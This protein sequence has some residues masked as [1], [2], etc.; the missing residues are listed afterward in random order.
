MELKSALSALESH[1]T[2][3]GWKSKNKDAYFSH[4]FRMLQDEHADWQLGFYQKKKEKITTFVVTL[5]AVRMRDAEEVF[6][7]EECDIN[8][9]EI[10]EKTLDLDEVVKRANTFQQKNYPR[11]K[12][13]KIIALLQCLPGFGSV[14]NLTFVTQQLNTLNMKIHSQSGDI[15]DHKLSSVF[16]FRQ[17]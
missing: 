17:E 12:S 9:V 7:R 3:S 13:M 14:W 6:K 16:S 5:D 11:D 15:L 10:S 8:P 4:A 2:F 1:P